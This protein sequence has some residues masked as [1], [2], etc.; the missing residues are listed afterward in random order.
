MKTNRPAA[1]TIVFTICLMTISMCSCATNHVSSIQ[2]DEKLS[3]ICNHLNSGLIQENNGVFYELKPTDTGFALYKGDEANKI[4]EPVDTTTTKSG[5]WIYNDHIFYRSGKSGNEIRSANTDGS[6]DILLFTASVQEFVVSDSGIFWTDAVKGSLMYYDF[7]SQDQSESA[8]FSAFCLQQVDGKISCLVN[9]DSE[10]EYYEE[11]SNKCLSKVLT[12]PERVQ[13]YLRLGGK[14]Y[15]FA[16][17]SIYEGDLTDG[18][19]REIM[20][21]FQTLSTS[22]NVYDGKIIFCGQNA[23]GQ[24]TY[25][26]DPER[27]S[28]ITID[29]HVY[30]FIFSFDSG[31]W[32]YALDC[33]MQK[34]NL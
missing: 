6:E 25:L 28:V 16:N 13:K 4:D 32:E 18:S 27:Q 11:G 2:Y 30:Q 5:F 8:P 17:Y 21:N 7:T 15:A 23:D 24:H 22:V 9:L 20:A 31:L 29:N 33:G 26:F 34:I 10:T 19:I 1:L 14:V 3:Q 12:F